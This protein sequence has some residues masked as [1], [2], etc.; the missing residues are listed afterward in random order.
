MKTNLLRHDGTNWKVKGGKPATPDV[1]LAFL[2]PKLTNMSA[3]FDA[4]RRVFPRS[5]VVGC[6]TGGE[7]YEDDALENSAAG[8]AISFDDETSSAKLASALQDKPEDSYETGAS[9]AR[10]LAGDDLAGVFVISDGLLVNGTRLIAGLQSVLGKDIPINGGLAGDG[11][12]FAATSV[13][14][15]NEM[16][17]GQVA[18]IGF[19]GKAL[20]MHDGCYAGWDEFGHERT[21]TRS[22]DN[23]LY[24]LNG[25]PALDIYKRYLGDEAK[26]LP[27]SALLYPLKIYKPGTQNHELIRSVIGVDEEAKSLIF[28]GDVPEGYHA[29]LMVGN[30]DNLVTGAENAA[31]SIPKCDPDNSVALLVSCIGRFLVLGPRSYEEVTEVRDILGG[32]PQVGFYSYGEISTHNKS[33]QCDLHNQTMTIT[34]LEEAA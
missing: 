31:K 1:V 32:I 16:Q 6:S 13:G 25:K 8:V 27:G 20:K 24:E 4:L 17:S 5:I 30:S 3:S 23:V 21:V 18:L 15:N 22:K 34:V 9:L 11:A 29:R 10:Q 2:S 26:D 19:Y 7:I 33:G 14:A 12:D 28:A